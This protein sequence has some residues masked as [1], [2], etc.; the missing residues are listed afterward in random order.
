MLFEV[1]TNSNQESN[2]LETMMTFCSNTPG[3]AKKIL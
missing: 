2:A 3:K 1:F